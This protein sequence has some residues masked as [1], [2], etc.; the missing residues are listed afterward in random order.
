[1]N[2]IVIPKAFALRRLHSLTG[3]GITLYLIEHLFVNSQAPF[4]NGSD[5][6]NSVNG[7]QALPYLRIIEVS[8]IG[9]PLL[10]HAIYGLIYA[11]QAAYDSM[12]TD[13]STPAL[14]QYARN[15]AFTWQ[16][17][18]S[19]ILLV[20]ILLHVYHMR[21]AN[22]PE[23][24]A[25]A[26]YVPVS[27]TVDTQ[28]LDVQLET[29]NGEHVAKTK[30]FGTAELIV[31]RETFKS[32]FMM[33]LYTLLVL[34][35]CFHGFNGLWTFCL[36]WGVIVSERAQK[37]TLRICYGLMFLITLCGLIAIYGYLL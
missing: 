15:Q 31:V 28:H 36:S 19:Y 14:P 24:E 22:Y 10:F 30:D 33:G 23:E 26:F 6:I 35:A 11:R 2:Q 21:F 3:L 16:R 32:P 37:I 7:I 20:G 27:H 17:L 1:M 25:N 29:R 18:T 12:R 13:G 9:I 34:A 4:S 5:F 8:L